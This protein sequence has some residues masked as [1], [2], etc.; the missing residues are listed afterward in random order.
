MLQIGN[1]KSETLPNEVE[2]LTLELFRS[3]EEV[4]EEEETDIVPVCLPVA[5]QCLS[6]R[7]RLFHLLDGVGLM[8]F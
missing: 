1:G 2:T 6:V 4:Q 8:A 5:T 3:S 7:L